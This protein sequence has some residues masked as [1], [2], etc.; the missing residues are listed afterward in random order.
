MVKRQVAKRN[1]EARWMSDLHVAVSWSG[2]NRPSVVILEMVR[3]RLREGKKAEVV[4]I[5]S[6]DTRK[7]EEKSRVGESVMPGANQVG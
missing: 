3:P 2:E 1:G 7:N 6:R 5:G 4:F